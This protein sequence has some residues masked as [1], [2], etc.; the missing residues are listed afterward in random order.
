MKVTTFSLTEFSA[1]RHALRNRSLI[2]IALLLSTA[3]AIAYSRST[4][5]TAA[6]PPGWFRNGSQVQNYDISV[7]S[8]VKHGGRAS[9]HVKSIAPTTNGFGGFMQV[10]MADA[11]HGK[12]LRMSAWLRSANAE[13][14]QLWLRLDGAK[15]TLG[16][17]N[18]ANR[19]LKG[20]SDWKKYELTLD[21]PTSTIYVAFGVMVIGNGEAWVDDFQFETVG[22]D[23]VT[24]NMLTAEQMKEQDPR[25][26]IKHP[27]QPVNLNFEEGVLTPAETAARLAQET[28]NAN[29][30]RKW[31]AANAIRLNTVEAR[32]GFADMQP[33]NK[34][35]GDARI[36]AL[37][38]ATHGSREFFQLKHRML[39]YLATE[40]GFTI[41]SI[42]ANMPEAY[43]LNDYVL[44]GTGDPA[45][46]IK[47]MYFW[48]WSTEEV[49][50][51][52]QWMREFNKSGKGRVEFTGFDMQTPDVAAGIV[53]D[54]I[55]RVD[56]DYNA[57]VRRAVDNIKNSAPRPN[58]GVATAK[59]PVKEAAGKR[60]HFSG[61]IKTE[62]VTNGFA[63][64][65][66]RVDGASGVLAFDNMQDRGVVGTTDWKRY[67]I[68]LPVAADAKNINFGAI[69]SGAGTAWFDGL[70]VQLDG[71][72][73]AGKTDFD[74]D[75]ESPLPGGFRT[76]G[77]G[78][79]VELDS[80]TFHDGKQSLRMKR[81]S[82]A[83]EAK[84]V[85][86][87]VASS[88]W[89][90]IVQHLEA[91]RETYGKKGMATR[92]V[93]WA[94]QNARVVLQ[95]MQMQAN[96]VSRDQSMADNIKW[97]A[98]QN[99][100]AKIVLWAHNG[101]VAT[102]SE[103]GFEAMGAALRKMFGNQM[104][105]F[106]FAFNQGSFQAVEMP[107]PS[108]RGLRNFNVGPA[109]EG[110]LD[111]MLASAGL[112]IAAIDLRRLANQGEVANWFREPRATKSIGAG[113]G[114][115]FAANFYP[116]QVAPKIYDVIL[117]I[118]KT[119]AA[120]PLPKGAGGP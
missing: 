21:V 43:R 77:N 52:V 105:V 32:H 78:Y 26:V 69:L 54:F 57:T 51:M 118:E 49:L 97:I 75:F 81:S 2:V 64:L 79:L 72:P 7:D 111:A 3:G 120:I 22:Q 56:P 71:T 23:V 8:T 58:F 82:T 35:I 24:T 30:A 65:W 55:G 42:E 84:G 117:F 61:Y 92:D 86:P 40:K 73:Y 12:R 90:E 20:T 74:L 60:A 115:E 109:P 103:G 89:K 95:S 19:A 36:V 31:L 6:D 10:I 62:N 94:I 114:E 11:Y 13:A 91:S 18:M 96:E 102:A 15:S 47:G 104:I 112:N 48:T 116:K 9:A 44:N 63:G 101:H 67:D 87:K 16:F 85:D 83:N 28:A 80:Q 50:D 70:S 38:E 37:G 88:A 76:G 98:D 5:T 45:T 66:W 27:L 34:L 108:K 41:F 119:T 106:G 17:D 68:E 59:F 4:T 39:E 14:V 110:S 25:P 33:L 99:P 107:F 93:E 46:L 1:N 29:A 53:N 100:G 113:Y